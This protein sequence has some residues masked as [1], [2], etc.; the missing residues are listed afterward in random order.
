MN[1]FLGIAKQLLQVIGSA[2]VATVVSNAVKST[3][4][5]NASNLTKGLSYVGEFVLTG[6]ASKKAAEYIGEEF[7]KMFPPA[8]AEPK[9]VVIEGEE[10]K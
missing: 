5:Y 1:A 8:K 4:P 7:D 9:K 3:T 2:G 10:V 6:L